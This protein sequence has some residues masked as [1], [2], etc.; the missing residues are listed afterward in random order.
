MVCTSAET[1]RFERFIEIRLSRYVVR[2]GVLGSSARREKGSKR[3]EC[4]LGT[5]LIGICGWDVVGAL[6]KARMEGRASWTN[7]QVLGGS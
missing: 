1:Q 5:M 7:L 4:S 6:G 3:V 2:L